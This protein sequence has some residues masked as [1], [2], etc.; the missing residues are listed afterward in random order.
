M[1]KEQM[2]HLQNLVRVLESCEDVG[3]TF[4]YASLLINIENEQSQYL[5]HLSAEKL[6]EL[7]NFIDGCGDI[8]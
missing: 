4:S 2:E 7:L 1:N 3:L 5:E 6:S 8:N